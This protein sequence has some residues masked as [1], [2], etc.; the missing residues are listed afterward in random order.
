MLV[1][2]MKSKVFNK[3][4]IFYNFLTRLNQSGFIRCILL[5]IHSY[6]Y[7][8]DQFI[9]YLLNNFMQVKLIIYFILFIFF[10]F[11][12]I[13]L[14]QYLL[15]LVLLVAID[16]FFLYLFGCRTKIGLAFASN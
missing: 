8:M 6:M 14:Y 7:C 15:L 2:L 12:N 5:L 13:Y 10:F 4:N 16:S 1:I 9:Y 3:K 11:C